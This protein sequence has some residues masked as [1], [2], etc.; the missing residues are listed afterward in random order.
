MRLR[1]LAPLALFMCLA[2]CDSDEKAW[3]NAQTA[4]TVDAYESYLLERD[5]G[6]FR[7]AAESA[8]RDL[9]EPQDWAEAVEAHSP[10][11]YAAY[12]ER[13]PES[14]HAAD[15]KFYV[16]IAGAIAG[17]HRGIGRPAPADD[18][19]FGEIIELDALIDAASETGAAS[20]E[21]Q[22]GAQLG[23]MI[24]PPSVTFAIEPFSALAGYD[25][26]FAEGDEVTLHIY[27]YDG[28]FSS[29]DFQIVGVRHR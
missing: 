11:G 17:V 1:D 8:I 3:E 20:F 24:V 19:P 23:S 9:E 10:A 28:V 2:A 16:E 27:I 13:H 12:L 5:D 21:L 18:A 25:A 15:A 7:E 14:A 6:Q 26:G 29:R 4:G 22:E